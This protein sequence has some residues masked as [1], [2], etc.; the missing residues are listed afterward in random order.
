LVGDHV[1]GDHRLAVAG[2]GSVKDTVEERQAEQAP[3]RAAVR[4]G[5]ADQPG[6]LFVEFGLLGED[7][8]DHT[9]R[10]CGWRRWRPRRPERA[11]LREYSVED[12]GD[13]QRAGND[14]DKQEEKVNQSPPDDGFLHGHFTWILLAN[15]EPMV[16]DGSRWSGPSW[17]NC[18]CS[19]APISCGLP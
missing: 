2:T 12:A 6:E 4:L 11:G 8:A 3:G 15:S 16:S 14:R 7:P 10:G 17:L 5:G 1:G 9:G 19:A 18:C 13:E